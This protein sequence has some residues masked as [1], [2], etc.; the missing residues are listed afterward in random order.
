[1]PKPALTGRGDHSEGTEVNTHK[2]AY[3]INVINNP[4]SQSGN[5][6]VAATLRGFLC[7]RMG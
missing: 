7:K 2:R 3:V 5:Q 1:M 6:K 4:K